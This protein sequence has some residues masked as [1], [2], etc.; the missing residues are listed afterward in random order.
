[1]HGLVDWAAD[2]K[3]PVFQCDKASAYRIL[4]N[5]KYIQ[6][7]EARMG[8]VASRIVSY[9]LSAGHATIEDI[10]E[11]CVPTPVEEPQATSG[12]SVPHVN[13][14]LSRGT[15][16]N[17]R[18]IRHAVN[19]GDKGYDTLLKLLQSGF[20]RV[21]HESIFRSAEDNRAEAEKNSK[22]LDDY[23]G[24]KK[25]RLI[26]WEQ[27]V[28][29]KLDDWKYGT[30]SERAE[31]AALAIHKKRPLEDLDEPHNN[32]RLRINGTGSKA[33]VTHVLDRA[34]DSISEYGRLKVKYEPLIVSPLLG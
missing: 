14:N 18:T 28:Q 34:K 15:K 25:A 7:I 10:L 31:I 17:G 30:N 5:G 2:D 9:I 13:G 8:A 6:A 12:A 27:A 21:S 19:D 20:L 24:A 32:K 1:M 22:K 29:C 4:R 3:G 26:E 11:A 33:H 16:E 23:K